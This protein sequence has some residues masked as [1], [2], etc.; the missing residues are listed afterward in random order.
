MCRNLI[1]ST[2]ERD[3]GLSGETEEAWTDLAEQGSL[4]RVHGLGGGLTHSAGIE[5]EWD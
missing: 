4:C 3:Y 1:T 2:T 5:Q